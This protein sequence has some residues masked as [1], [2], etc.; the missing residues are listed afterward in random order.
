MPGTDATTSPPLFN[1]AAPSKRKNAASWHT[2][3]VQFAEW[4][5][6]TWNDTV[7]RV[8]S[9]AYDKRRNRFAAIQFHRRIHASG[10]RE[11]LPFTPD[12]I[13]AALAAYASCPANLKLGSWKSFHDWCGEAEEL[14]EKHLRRVG[15]ELGAAAQDPRE[16]AARKLHEHLGLG[17]LAASATQIN[18]TL[19]DHVVAMLARLR[20]MPK[21]RE[22]DSREFDHYE[23]LERLIRARGRLS[24]AQ[25]SVLLGRATVA[26]AAL[27][28]RPYG[29]TAAD[30]NDVAALALAILDRETKPLRKEKSE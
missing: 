10:D 17:R 18:S 15:Y 3:E 16:A 14:I 7:G 11:A 20:R 12:S 25:E 4:L 23:R 19:A 29:G 24:S 8:G 5:M 13:R 28:G 9:R 21:W 2:I 30:S 6:R 27:R 22:S 1:D 26:F